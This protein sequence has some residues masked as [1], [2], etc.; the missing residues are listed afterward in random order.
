MSKIRLFL[1]MI[2]FEHTIFALPYAYIGM[3]MAS[4][5]T[6]QSWPPLMTF[7]WVTLAMVG[8]R[9]A[10][11]GLNR[12][13]DAAIDA[14][15]PRTANREIPSGKIKSVEAWLFIIGSLALLG[16]S[17]YM[18]N[19]LCFALL[20]LAVAV[21]VLYPY[22]KRFTWACHLV[23][24]L[25]DSFAP[26][27]GWIAVTGSF[28]MPSLLLAGAVAVWIAAFDIIYACQDVE[29]DKKNGLHSIP[30]RFGIAGGLRLSRMM[31]IL[32]I[33]LFALVPLYV[34]LGIVYWI[35]V[36]AVAGLLWYEHRIISPNDMSR[37]DLAFF[38]V[39]SYVASVAF[40]FTLADIA[41]SLW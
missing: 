6:T 2:K 18:L 41:I 26:L 23:L 7:V 39:N 15:N 32:T 38:T 14:R 40:V 8:A 20:P 33:V 27:G 28:D 13:I 36:A 22:C 11:M 5:Y 25:A 10:A 17:A 37:I 16:V 35:G 12:V 24:G 29:F 34:D 4:Y 30:V 21:L 3:V 19:P 1:E 31:H 9:S